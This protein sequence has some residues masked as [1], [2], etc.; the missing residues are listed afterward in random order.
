[1]YSDIKHQQ[2]SKFV[3]HLLGC[4]LHTVRVHTVGEITDFNIKE[5]I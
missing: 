1:M 5:Q 4:M 3:I 2:N